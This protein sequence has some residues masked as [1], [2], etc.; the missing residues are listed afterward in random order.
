MNLL[1]HVYRKIVF[2]HDTYI[3]ASISHVNVSQD[4]VQEFYT[5]VRKTK[6]R[7]SMKTLGL[8]DI[9]ADTV[10]FENL[11]KAL[12]IPNVYEYVLRSFDKD[13]LVNL[14]MKN[15]A[16]FIPFKNIVK[17]ERG[18]VA[19]TDT[20]EITYRCPFTGLTRIF[21]IVYDEDVME[22]I[23]QLCRFNEVNC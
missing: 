10:S 14:V 6:T 3:F 17:V 8:E 15:L 12:R 5:S 13:T 11:L 9:P 16:W 1:L 7:Q 23:K 18:R 21:R 19:S 2:I 22:R 4:I 20:I